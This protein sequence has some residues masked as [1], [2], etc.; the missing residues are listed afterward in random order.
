MFTYFIRGDAHVPLS[1]IVGIVILLLTG[2]WVANLLVGSLAVVGGSLVGKVV[3]NHVLPLFLFAVK[4]D[5]PQCRTPSL[6]LVHPVG[7]SRFRN[8]D[9]MRTLNVEILVVVGKDGN[10]L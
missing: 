9:E 5:D 1:G 7:Q 2:F 10:A 6:Q 3:I 4:F 8:D